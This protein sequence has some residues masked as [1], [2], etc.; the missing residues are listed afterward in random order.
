MNMLL[1]SVLFLNLYLVI[2]KV[3]QFISKN[4]ES[5][6]IASNLFSAQLTTITSLAILFIIF[7]FPFGDPYLMR[8]VPRILLFL[9]GLELT[10]ISVLDIVMLFSKEKKMNLQS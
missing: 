4:K 1:Y 9:I 3:I 2:T 8:G 10:T 6:N 7:F 5:E